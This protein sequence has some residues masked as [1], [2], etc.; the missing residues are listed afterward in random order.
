LLQR[1]E[2]LICNLSGQAVGPGA[3]CDT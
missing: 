1:D 3:N 2:R